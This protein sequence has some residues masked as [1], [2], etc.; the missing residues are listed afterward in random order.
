V[1]KI[2]KNTID[3]AFSLVIYRFLDELIG[4]VGS[5][6]KGEASSKATSEREQLKSLIDEEKTKRDAQ[7]SAQD[8]LDSAS[9][10]IERLEREENGLE[11]RKE[12]VSSD[13]FVLSSKS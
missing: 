3:C 11:E 12:K 8:Q 9:S 4:R 6:R 1:R 10:K 13:S 2:W 7:S 5:C